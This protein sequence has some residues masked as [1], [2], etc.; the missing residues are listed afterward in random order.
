VRSKMVPG[1]HDLQCMPEH[2]A[3][4]RIGQVRPEFVV[5]HGSKLLAC[6]SRITRS[7]K[8]K[9]K[10]CWPR[11][12]VDF[13]PW[14][15][16]RFPAILIV[17]SVNRDTCDSRSGGRD[18]PRRTCIAAVTLAVVAFVGACGSGGESSSG[19]P[20]LTGAQ[21]D[22]PVLRRGRSVFVANCARCHG[23]AGEGGIGPQLA[24]GRVV[25][26]YPDIEDQIAVV[27]NGRGA[28]PS[29]DGALS[30]AEIRAVVRYER[31]VP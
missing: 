9:R 19:T 24:D 16:P 27:T 21:A 7:R 29:F 4:D 26:R 8:S 6:L 30:A 2:L 15:V 17:M 20:P 12:R 31:E 25:D 5:E 11:W 23:N 3:R 13:R 14:S 1:R 22:D 10:V 28:M 18:H